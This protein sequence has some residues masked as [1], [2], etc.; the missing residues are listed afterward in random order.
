MASE[1][2]ALLR[3]LMQVNSAWST[4][5]KEALLVGL[6]DLSSLVLRLNDSYESDETHWCTM[7]QHVLATLCTLGGFRE[8]VRPGCTAVVRH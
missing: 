5:V 1:V 6:D 4:T 2:V 8:I 3:N 7:A